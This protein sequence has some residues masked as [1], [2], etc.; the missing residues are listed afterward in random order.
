MR[1]L[2][3][4]HGETPDNVSGSLGTV[5]PGPGLT[6]LGLRQAAA[7]PAALAD[8][9]IVGIYVSRMRRTH[10]TAAPLAEALGIEPV[11]LPGIHEID[12]GRLEGRNDLDAVYEYMGTLLSWW[13][14]P[15]A[16]VGESGTEFFARF[17]A[18]VAR[19]AGE[20]DGTVALFS[21]G[22]AIRAWSSN[23]S[24]NLDADNTRTR[25]LAN[26]AMVVL[27]GSPSTGWECVAW[28]DEPLGGMILDDDTAADPTGDPL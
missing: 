28:H 18:D 4:R 16:R 13:T 25:A 9:S 3:I 10:L 22:A 5:I 12:A 6:P 7:V 14:D 27:E 24:T 19:I 8:E 2:L 15:E 11:E 20:H 1:L 21:H 17:D 23:V 26:T